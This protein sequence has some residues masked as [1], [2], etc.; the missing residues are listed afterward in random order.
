MIYRISISLIGTYKVRPIVVGL[1]PKL[2]YAAKIF[3]LGSRIA[4]TGSGVIG[5]GFGFGEGEG[6]GA[7]MEV[8]N[9]YAVVMQSSL[10][11]ADQ[12]HCPFLAPLRKTLPGILEPL[13]SPLGARHR[14]R[15]SPVD[16]NPPTSTSLGKSSPALYSAKVTLH[17]V[18]TT[19]TSKW[20]NI[21][22]F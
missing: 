9:M 4:G 3:A 8:P 18:G 2:R 20:S 22:P 5:G 1:A 17:P 12:Q 10:K 16:R 13:P 6:V 21:D 11:P 14:P 19:A 15:V 7:D